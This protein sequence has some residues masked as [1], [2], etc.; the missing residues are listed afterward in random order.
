MFVKNENAFA[1]F[2]YVEF[3]FL[4]SAN[5]QGHHARYEEEKPAWVKTSKESFHLLAFRQEELG[6]LK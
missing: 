2:V 4:V 6:G 5:S 3:T 1:D